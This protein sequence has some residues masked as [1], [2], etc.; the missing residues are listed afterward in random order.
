MLQ[1]RQ[2][3]RELQSMRCDFVHKLDVSAK[4]TCVVLPDRSG[5]ERGS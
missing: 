3:N 2:K 5:M 1:V 4:R